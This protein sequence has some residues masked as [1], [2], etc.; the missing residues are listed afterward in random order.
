MTIL[1]FPLVT[2]SCGAIDAIYDLRSISDA[3]AGQHLENPKCSP[4]FL[5]DRLCRGRLSHTTTFLLTTTTTASY[6]TMSGRRLYVGRLNE[7]ATKDDVSA[8]FSTLG[9]V[10]DI[11]MMGTFAFIEY[12]DLKNAE[13]AVAEFS[14]KEFLGQRLMVEFA[15][16][17]RNIDPDREP[18]SVA[19]HIK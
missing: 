7:Q 16:P 5:A 3:A 19:S 6:D 2:M 12:E 18:R 13:D 11:R 4:F 10:V 9:K 1:P 14:G 8:H 15:K 17:P